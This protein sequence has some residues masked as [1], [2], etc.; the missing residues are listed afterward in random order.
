[1]TLLASDKFQRDIFSATQAVRVLCDRLSLEIICLQHFSFYD[2]LLD[3]SHKD[4]LVNEKLALWFM[5]CPILNTDLIQVSAKFLGPGPATKAR[6]TTGDMSVIVSDL[7]R[8]ADLGAIQRPRTIR[9]T[10]E[11]LCW[12][13]HIDTW[14]ALW[15]VIERVDRPNFGIYLDTFNIA[16][17]IYADPACPTGKTPNAK[18]ELKKSIIVDAE[19]LDSPLNESHPFHVAGQP[20]RMNWSRNARLFAFEEDRGGYLPILEVANAFFDLGFE[21]WVSLELFSRTLLEKHIKVPTIGARATESQLHRELA[22]GLSFP[23]GNKNG[24]D[25]GLT[26]AI[27]A[28]GSASNLHRYLGV[29]KQG[30]AAITKTTGNKHGFVIMRGGKQGTNYDRKSIQQARDS[31]AAKK[32]REV[33]MVD[34]SHGNSNKNHRNQPIVAKDV[35]EQLR[36]SQDAIIGVMIE[37][38]LGEGNQKVPAEGPSGLRRGVSI[39]DACIDWETTVDILED[40]ADAVRGRRA[41]KIA[42]A[43]G[44]VHQI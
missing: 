29:T 27:D 43:K 42:Q 37:S 4:E 10:Y 23:I 32:Q 35:G 33:V 30:L 18:I 16:G 36:G 39:T 25:G 11:A 34:C 7:Q 31:L 26:V 22:S 9:F 44:V 8:I 5:L 20:T 24:T 21:G 1:M 15:E 28:I 40:L 17:R 12:S 41:A 38:N 13:D 19:R 2:G 6:R 14:E 3:Q